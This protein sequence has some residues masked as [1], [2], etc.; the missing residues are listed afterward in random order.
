MAAEWGLTGRADI[1]DELGS[2]VALVSQARQDTQRRR[3][4]R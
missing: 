4:G 1:K 2:A 3:C